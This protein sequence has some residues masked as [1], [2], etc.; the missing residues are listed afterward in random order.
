MMI[1]NVNQWTG[2]SPIGGHG[3]ASADPA[4]PKPA[5]VQESVGQ[6]LTA[7]QFA[8]TQTPASG[9]ADWKQVVDPD[10]KQQTELVGAV[11]DRQS[12]N[13]AISSINQH[14]RGYNTSLRFEVDDNYGQ[15]VIKVVDQ[16]TKEMVRQIPSETALALG[17]F[18]DDMA[19][20]KARHAVGAISHIM[21]TAGFLFHGLT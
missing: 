14:L 18:F 12:L 9:Q 11:P 17:Q 8:V 16:S 4:P 15:P 5:T 6:L 13:D 1:G 20:M 21:P 19:I 2:T 7:A 3:S 10:G